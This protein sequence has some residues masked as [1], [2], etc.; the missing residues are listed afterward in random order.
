MTFDGNQVSIP[1][2][3]FPK[4]ISIQFQLLK[5]KREKRRRGKHHDRFNLASD[6]RGK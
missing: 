1:W 2:E 6:R 3:V 4:T 5:M